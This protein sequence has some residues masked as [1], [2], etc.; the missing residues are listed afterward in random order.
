MKRK[1]IAMKA[2]Q[3]AT[4]ADDYVFNKVMQDKIIV[5]ETLLRVLPDLKI[6]AV[7]RV[8]SQQELKVSCDAKG[9]RL[10]IYVLDDLNNRYDIEMQVVDH[11]NLP[12]RVRYYQ[13]SLA[14]DSYEK[15]ENYQAADNAY[16]IF[17][18]CFDPFGL[19]QQRYTVSGRIDECQYY[20]YTDGETT[21]F[22]NVAS[23]RK[24]VSPQLQSLL[25]LIADRKVEE[26]DPFIVK[27]RQRIAYVKHNR[28]WRDEYMRKTLAE[29]DYD[30]GLEQAKKQ[31]LEQGAAD[32][33]KI[34]VQKL[35]QNGQTHDQVIS[36]LEQIIGMKAEEAEEYY[37]KLTE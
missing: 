22:L 29:M 3:Q 33:Q 4:L 24:E 12:Q 14:M 2:W 6:Q 36:F 27:L 15:G 17:F 1:E 25:D 18:C 28:K 5:T 16:V 32:A 34:I 37:R 10:D 31:G 8:A 19:K 23:L 20:P 21:I 7:K 35:I 13:A 11:H 30:Y 26:K 9:V